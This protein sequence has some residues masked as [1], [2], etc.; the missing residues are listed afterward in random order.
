MALLNPDS[1]SSILW[2]MVDSEFPKRWNILVAGNASAQPAVIHVKNVNDQALVKLVVRMKDDKE[3]GISSEDC[4]WEPCKQG[5]WESHERGAL[6]SARNTLT[7]LAS[8][9]GRLEYV[10]GRKKNLPHCRELRL[11]ETWASPEAIILVSK[12]V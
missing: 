10:D 3:A 4:G 2:A 12:K 9:L 6:E 1:N 7:V 8:P 5:L 11:P